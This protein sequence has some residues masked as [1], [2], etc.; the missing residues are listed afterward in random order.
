MKADLA[1]RVGLPSLRSSR[2]PEALSSR[3]PDS[4]A[5]LAKR[6]DAYLDLMSALAPATRAPAKSP[7]QTPGVAGKTPTRR[8]VG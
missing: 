5:R 8:D 7:P 3:P 1:I 2:L 4:R 6:L